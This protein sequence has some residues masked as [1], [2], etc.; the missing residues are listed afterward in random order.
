M[1][2]ILK[3]PNIVPHG[4]ILRVAYAMAKMVSPPMVNI[5]L[6]RPGM[7]SAKLAKT[8]NP[9]KRHQL[10]FDNK[11]GKITKVYWGKMS[12]DFIRGD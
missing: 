11:E 1:Y 9:H 4:A 8:P 6:H 10:D 3:T 2:L 5:S 12:S 7:L